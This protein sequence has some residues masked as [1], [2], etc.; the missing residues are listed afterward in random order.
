MVF[1]FGFVTQADLHPDDEPVSLELVS[2]VNKSDGSTQSVPKSPRESWND[3]QPK[4]YV[5]TN[6][7]FKVLGATVDVDPRSLT[8]ILY[9]KEGNRIDPSA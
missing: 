8:P 1:T 6:A 9:D 4:L 7:F 3:G 2:A 5:S